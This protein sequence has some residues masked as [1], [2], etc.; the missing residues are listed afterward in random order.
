MTGPSPARDIEAIAR[1][2]RYVKHGAI[3][4]RGGSFPDCLCPKAACGGVADNQEHP[5]C[6][7]HTRVPAQVWHW[8]SECP[9]L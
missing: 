1:A 2:S 6:P 9:G 3:T 4:H 7:E 8:A 5:D